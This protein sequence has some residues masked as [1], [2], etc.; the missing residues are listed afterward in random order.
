MTCAR[1][2]AQAD[3]PMQWEESDPK[4]ITDSSEVSGHE[5]HC[6][7]MKHFVAVRAHIVDMHTCTARPLSS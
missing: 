5:P 3:V 6:A 2:D 7:A 4:H 1:A